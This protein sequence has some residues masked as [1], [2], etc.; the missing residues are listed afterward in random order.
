MNTIKDEYFWIVDEDSEDYQKIARKYRVVG[1]T[2][3]DKTVYTVQERFLFL[4][5]DVN[6]SNESCEP[7]LV[8][9]E[10]YEEAD[11]MRK[12][13]IQQDLLKSKETL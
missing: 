9:Y 13:L 4:W 3:S 12:C 5:W 2:D 7:M 1:S 8:E 11:R 10:S 6:L